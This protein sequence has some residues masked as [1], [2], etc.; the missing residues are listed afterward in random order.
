MDFD[1]REPWPTGQHVDGYCWCQ[2]K[3]A[4]EDPATGDR[5]YLHHHE[6]NRAMATIIDAAEIDRRFD[7]HAPDERKRI[8]HEA[9]RDQVKTTATAL[10]AM[11]P[12]CREKSLAFTALEEALFYANAAIA[13]Q[14]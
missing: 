7:Y 10:A 4:Y 2:P 12:E 9:A 1:P 6:R 13:R 5:V 11:L 8:L 14:E 3:I